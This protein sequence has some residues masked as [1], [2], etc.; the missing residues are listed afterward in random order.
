MLVKVERRLKIYAEVYK[1]F[2]VNVYLAK[3]ISILINV[4]LLA[5]FEKCVSTLCRWNDTM[6][7]ILVKHRVLIATVKLN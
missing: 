4:S 2:A 3:S 6:V 7:I 5:P 1:S